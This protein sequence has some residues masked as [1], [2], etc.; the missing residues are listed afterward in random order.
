LPESLPLVLRETDR[1]PG[2]LSRS[3]KKRFRVC[4]FPELKGTFI[5]LA[6][7]LK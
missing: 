1:D 6:C 3:L 7:V 2:S 4:L 5:C